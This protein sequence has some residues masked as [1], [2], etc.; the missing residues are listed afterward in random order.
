MPDI[1]D[2]EGSL[3]ATTRE[4]EPIP[5]GAHVEIIDQASDGRVLLPTKVLV[6]GV[7]VGLIAEDGVEYER[8]GWFR[9]KKKRVE[10]GVAVEAG[11]WNDVTR[12]TLRL[13]P[14]R[15]TIRG[16]DDA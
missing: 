16:S 3:L 13:L 5:S 15:V 12:V 9:R 8:R 6:N 14:S 1:H 10:Y 2:N 11:S 7:D 4:S